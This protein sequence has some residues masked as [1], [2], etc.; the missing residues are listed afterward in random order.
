[1]FNESSVG[2]KGLGQGTGLCTC[3]EIPSLCWSSLSSPGTCSLPHRA[4]TDQL[5]LGLSCELLQVHSPSQF[6]NNTFSLRFFRLISDVCVG[7]IMESLFT[8]KVLVVGVNDF[9]TSNGIFKNLCWWYGGVW[10]WWQKAVLSLT[11]FFSQL[12]LLMMVVLLHIHKCVCVSIYAKTWDRKE[13]ELS[14]KSIFIWEASQVC[15]GSSSAKL[16]L[17]CRSFRWALILCLKKNL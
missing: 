8:S 13:K 6:L 1:M 2:R 15:H 14:T 5:A 11:A 10:I 3:W 9:L 7:S 17:M 4:G 12:I 16:V